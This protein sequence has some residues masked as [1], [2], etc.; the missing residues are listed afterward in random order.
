MPAHD[1]DLI[2][3]GSG[4]GGAVCALRAAQAGLRVVVLERGRHM[5]PAAFDALAAGQVPAFHGRDEPGLIEFHRCSGL[6]AVSASAVGGGSVIY[7]AVTLPAPAEVFDDGWPAGLDRDTLAPYY[8]RVAAMIS[9]TPIPRALSRTAALETLGGRIG[10][11][12]T[13]LP[14]SMD[15]PQEAS[16]LD[17]RPGTDGVYPELTAWIRG[18]HAARKRTLAETYLPQAEALGADIRPLHEVQAVIPEDGGY[19]VRYRCLSEPA[20]ATHLWHRHPGGESPAGRRCHNDR[21]ETFGGQWMEGTL[22]ARRVVLAAGVLGTTRLLLQCR[23]EHKTLLCLSHALGT[24]F[25]TN[26]DSGGL[27]VEPR[28]APTLDGGP[29]VTA[30]LD[31]W[32]TRRLF[33]METGLIPYDTGSFTGLLNPSK[34]LRGLRLAPARQCIWSFGV[35]GLEE[36]PGELR[37]SRRGKLVHRRDSRRSEDHRRKTMATL[38]ELAAAAEAKLIAPPALVAR[39]LPVTVHPLGGAVMADSAEAGVVDPLGEVFGHPGLYVADGS[40]VPT[41][42]GVPPSMT[43]AA[44]AER[45]AENMVM[46]C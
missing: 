1:C 19:Q 24:R 16:R 11:E 15:W 21:R 42:T 22:S 29:P 41:P 35:M 32:R 13:R 9:P 28:P 38:G 44:L 31:F 39:L 36:N 7:T 17:H 27:L 34:W 30:W 5:T 12:V 6:V 40:I 4:F 46:R 33:V 26:G 8:D 20:A 45:I 37:L 14:L 2:I 43:I 23:D 18:G 10:A 25:H 3:I